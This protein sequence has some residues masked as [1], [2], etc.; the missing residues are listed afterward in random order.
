M[1]P[2]PDYCYDR[3]KVEEYSIGGIALILGDQKVN[4]HEPGSDAE[5]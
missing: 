5:P 1:E 4:L 2:V 3:T